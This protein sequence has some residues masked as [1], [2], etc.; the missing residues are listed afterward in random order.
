MSRS[1]RSVCFFAPVRDPAVLQ[2]TGFYAQDLAILRNLGF[3]VHVA[4]RFTEIP[5]GC[6]LYFVW[7]WTWAFLPLLKAKARGRPVL[8]TGVLDCDSFASRPWTQRTLIRSGF[9]WASW[10]VIVSRYEYDWA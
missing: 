8:V 10:N 7:W 9:S 1:R 6:D 3:D 2:T 5:W 4:T